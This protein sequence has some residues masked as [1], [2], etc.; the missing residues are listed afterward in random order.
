M[1]DTAWV[2]GVDR[3]QAIASTWDNVYV[4][5]DDGRLLRWDARSA[6][7]AEVE[8]TPEAR[9]VLSA[10]RDV[11]VVTTADRVLCR[12]D[13][14]QIS[15]PSLDRDASIEE[16]AWKPIEVSD[17]VSLGGSE[18]RWVKSDGES[19][20][21]PRWYAVLR[22]GSV[23]SWETPFSEGQT[24]EVRRI[25]GIRKATHVAVGR[26]HA[27]AVLEGG[28]LRCW[29]HLLAVTS[30]DDRGPLPTAIEPPS[31]IAD[32]V[33]A[34]GRC[35]E[36]ARGPLTCLV[37]LDIWQDALRRGRRA[38]LEEQPSEVLRVREVY[39]S[40]CHVLRDGTVT[41]PHGAW[42][43]PAEVIDVALGQGF[44]CAL[45]RDRGVRCKR[46]GPRR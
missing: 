23:T 10:G 14:L 12:T 42:S 3:A 2:E 13:R 29:H 36:R 5:R 41:C 34:S 8:P 16:P 24:P 32:A 18:V 45:T 35:V 39:G 9:A 19:G 25:P 31:A 28:A 4:L 44:A 22:D 38:V 1:T 15:H 33:G 30:T 6:R 40:E 20:S 7:G 43:M 37:M 17:V 26:D 21:G 27:C 11:C 46:S